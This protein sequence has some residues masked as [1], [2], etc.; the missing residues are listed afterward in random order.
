MYTGSCRSGMVLADTTGEHTMP[1]LIHSIDTVA[2]IVDG[3]MIVHCY[4]TGR[5]TSFEIKS[6]ACSDNGTQTFG[7]Y[8]E[9]HGSRL[10]VAYDGGIGE[11]FKGT[12]K[13]NVVQYIDTMRPME[14]DEADVVEMMRVLSH[15]LKGAHSHI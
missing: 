15:G 9:E 11:L 4:A 3:H 5:M 14:A 2:A 12:T 10:I 8:H 6:E 7:L 13:Y 1:A